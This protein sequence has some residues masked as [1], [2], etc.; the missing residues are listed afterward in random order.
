MKKL[1][2]YIDGMSCGHCVKRVYNTLYSLGVE[3][4]EVEI[5]E[6]AIVFDEKKIN[7]DKIAKALNEVGYTLKSWQDQ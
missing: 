3:N 2:I 5:G 1:K 4:A 6:A 7:I